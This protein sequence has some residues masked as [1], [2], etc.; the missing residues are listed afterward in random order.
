MTVQELITELY[1]VPLNAEVRVFT[2][3]MNRRED[4]TH[5][6]ACDI[7]VETYDS[8]SAPTDV[9]IYADE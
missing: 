8:D 7:E 4:D 1:K 9:I 5:Y 2:S 6:W 3:D